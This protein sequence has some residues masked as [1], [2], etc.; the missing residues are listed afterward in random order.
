MLKNR[1][2][3]GIFLKVISLGVENIQTLTGLQ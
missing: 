3:T 1:N 2:L